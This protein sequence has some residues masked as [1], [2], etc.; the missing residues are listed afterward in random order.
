VN[1]EKSPVLHLVIQNRGTTARKRIQIDY[2]APGLSWLSDYA[3]VLDA[4]A[5]GEAPTAATL[6]SWVSLYNYTGVDLGRHS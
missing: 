5:K 1:N 2:L 6:D 4:V 3:L